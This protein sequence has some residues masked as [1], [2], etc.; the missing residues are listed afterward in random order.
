MAT[1]AN[2]ERAGQFYNFK[3]GN[4]VHFVTRQELP[5]LEL[6]RRPYKYRKIVEVGVVADSFI[7]ESKYPSFYLVID[8]N[9]NWI[10]VNSSDLW[11]IPK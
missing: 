8:K 2:Y 4:V 3:R 10:I 5:P 11:G 9:K 7:F 6:Y 1:L